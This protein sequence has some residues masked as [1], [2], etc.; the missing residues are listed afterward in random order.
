[1]RL[2]ATVICGALAG[3]GLA[4]ASSGP[5]W[6]T[7]AT[8]IASPK[9]RSYPG[10]IRLAVDASDAERRIVHVRETLSGVDAGTVLL[11]PKW[12]P[13]MHAPQ[14]P[15]DRLA[16]IKISANGAAVRWVRD[17][18]D[19]YAFRLQLAPAD[20]SIDIEFDYL[21]PTS[22]RVGE[23]EISHDIAILD[24]N[25]FV[26]YPA[27]FYARRI[28][29]DA[30]ITL[31][32]NWKVGTALEVQSESGAHTAFKRVDLETLVDSPIYA[33]RYSARI[34]LDPGGAAPVHLDVFADRPDLLS[35]SE[36][37]LEAHRAL[38]QQTY[39][40]FRS[41][42][43][44]HYDFLYSLSEQVQQ[45][46]IEHLESS[47]NGGDPGAFTDW[48]RNAF[49][50]SLLAHEFSHSWNGKFR[51]PADLWT[52][53]FNVP[54]LGSLLWVYEGQTQY[55]GEVLAARSGL[56]TKQQ[57][58]DQ[59]ALTAGYYD[60]E[61]GEYW[62]ALQDTTNDPIINP[63]RPMSWRDYQRFEDYYAE[64][65][66]I[67]LDADTLIRE[68]TQGKR[69]LDDFAKD[70][71]G[72]DEGSRATV[73]YTFS[74]VVSTLEAIM[75]YDW[76]G[77]LRTR[78]DSVAKPAPLDGLRRGGYKLTYTDTPS[79]F[80]KTVDEKRKHLNLIFSIGAEIDN[81]DGTVALSM[82]NSPAFKA[83]LT[84]GAQILSVNGAAYSAE[85]L[86]E[87]ILEAK[88]NRDPIQLIIKTGER[89]LIANVDYHGGPRFPHLERDQSQPG[90]LDEILA[91]RH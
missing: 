29:V 72:I 80:Q 27:G 50:R 51:R 22:L 68:R 9:D 39:K 2:A 8:P 59:L 79:D 37:Q 91:A 31:P 57:A 26:L 38:V 34:D 24:W 69:S 40:L 53:N 11:Y 78:L 54:M 89:Y 48:D 65:Q 10:E 32:A 43:F 12:L 1:M 18:V 41:R 83:K 20:R 13:G 64:G 70:F 5:V 21:S 67:W 58:L 33:G 47:E 56:W 4:L 45:K 46:G 66:L 88:D 85:A 62:R 84:E 15:I 42:H 63:R 30:G 16:G 81:R 82:W 3:V 6:T 71:F 14:G 77:F 23:L 49:R 19:V 76:A 87:A 55:W 52:P 17:P 7:I 73:T 74:D 25:A 44:A 61:T 86:K 36:P 90:R 28:P 75:P 35:I 60:M